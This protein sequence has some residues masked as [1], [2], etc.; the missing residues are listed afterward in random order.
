MPWGL[1]V[2]GF[3]SVVGSVLCLPLSMLV[4]YRATV[5]LGALV[6]LL[7]LG[8]VGRLPRAAPAQ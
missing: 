5:L 4:G 6:Y 8:L 1:G 7:P 2:N 3:A